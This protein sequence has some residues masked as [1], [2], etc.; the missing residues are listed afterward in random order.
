VPRV[1]W[2]CALVAFLNATAWA[3]ITP[4]FQGKDEVDHFAYIAQ[5][6]ERGTLPEPGGGGENEYSPEQALTMEALHYYGVRFTPFTPSLASAAEQQTLSQALHAGASTVPATTGA[7][8]AT[9]EPPLYYALQ[10]IP[11]FLAKGNIINQLELMRLVGALF[12][13]LTALFTLLFLRELLPRAHWAATVGALCVALE[14]L[15]GFIS[16]S[17]NPESM[18]Y[19]IAAA[20]FYRLARAFRRGLTVRLGI[21]L[22]V[23]SAVGFATK[24]NFIGLAGGEF[25]GLAWLAMREARRHGARALYAPASAFGIVVVP[26]LIYALGKS[27]PTLGIATGVA[28]QASSSLL[29][30]I[31]Y[32]WQLF[33]PRLPGMHHYFVGIFTTKDVW[34]DRSVGLY[35]WMDTMF[36]SWVDD[37]AL[38]FAVAVAALCARAIFAGRGA[39]RARLP[40]LAV[41][42]LMAVGVLAM[43]GFASYSSDVIGKE[44]AFGEPRYLLPLLPLLGLGFVLAV[45]GA[46]RRWAP[47]AGAA[48]VV[49]LLGYDLIS[50]LQV[51]ARYYG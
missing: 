26:I 22:G 35:G 44:A 17:V 42:A 41:Y 31:S 2:I 32:A 8:I 25:A 14:P 38:V 39:L 9:S 3:L 21:V 5:L 49:L 6:A 29:D 24:L 36:P 50:Q 48:L 15:L 20:V 19:P 11:Y 16:A 18:V 12:A 23:L 47:V 51:I 28:H 46:G 4:P 30:E 37:V 45:R 40:E 10:T 13:A 34:F 27:H 43:I 7:G 33:L 1:A